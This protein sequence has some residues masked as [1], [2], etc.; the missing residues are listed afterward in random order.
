LIAAP[1][2]MESRP[3]RVPH[4]MF[5]ARPLLLTAAIAL[6]ALVAGAFPAHAAEPD[7]SGY[8][9]LLRRYVRVLKA[10]GQPWDSRFDYEQLYIDENIQSLRRADGLA[11]IHTQLLSVSPGDMSERERTAWAINAYNFLALERMTL[12]LLVP[13]RRF[14]RYDSPRE[15]NREEGSFFAAP[16][17]TVEG[18]SYSLAGFERRF[19]YGDTTADPLADGMHAREKA[20]DP[21]LQLALVKASLASGPILPWVYRADSLE[22]QLDRAA[23]LAL[24]LPR[25][26][27]YDAATGLLTASNRFFEERADLGGPEMP[28]LMPLISKHAPLAVRKGIQARKLTRVSMFFEPNWKLNQFDHPKPKLPGAAADSVRKS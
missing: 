4:T 27:K 15:V 5:A 1:H 10:P 17:A 13:G 3:S 16:V 21:R 25:L 28:G 24:A 6:L 7:Y 19:V 11:R 23:R 18:R 14:L 20:G 8:A 26:V 12:H 2:I 22:A 9:D